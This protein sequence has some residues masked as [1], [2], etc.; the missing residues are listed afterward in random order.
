[1]AGELGLGAAAARFCLGAEATR[2]P[3]LGADGRARHAGD[4]A[5]LAA[6]QGDGGLALAQPASEPRPEVTVDGSGR[7]LLEVAATGQLEPVAASACWRAWNAA[8]LA[9]VAGLA[10]RALDLAV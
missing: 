9:Y 2:G 7:V 1:G 8:T 6:P 10:H 4:A 3:P 5:S